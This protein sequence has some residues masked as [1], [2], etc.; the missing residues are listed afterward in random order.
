M[1]TL[2]QQLFNHR[3]FLDLYNRYENELGRRFPFFRLNTAAVAGPGIDFLTTAS[4]IAASQV[5]EPTQEQVD[6]VVSELYYRALYDNQF[7]IPIKS[8]PSHHTS[9]FVLGGIWG[10]EA[11]GPVPTPVMV[12]GK[13]PGAEATTRRINFVEPSGEE[14]RKQVELAGGDWSHWYVTNIVRHRQLSTSSNNL[15]KDWIKNCLPL[16]QMELQIVRPTHILL[17]GTEAVK[18]LY[19]AYPQRDELGKKKSP[20]LKSA[21]AAVDTF[22][23]PLLD[24]TTHEAKVFACWHP[25]YILSEPKR[26]S[27]LANSV[28]K[29]VK[30]VR[31]HDVE[32][33]ENP[34]FHLAVRTT[35]Q[36]TALVDSL[37][38]MKCN[39]FAVD[40]EW[41][42][43][44][45]TEPNSYVRTV[46]FAWAGNA[47]A[48]VVLHAAGGEAAFEGGIIECAI[49]QLRRLLKGT[50]ERPVRIIGHYLNADMPWLISLGL[51]LRAEF[52]AP[53]EITGWK[54]RGEMA[55]WD[56]TKYLGGFDT[57]LAGHAVEETAELK[58][59][60][61]LNQRKGLPRYDLVLQKW[62]KQYCSEHGLKDAE[63][64]GYGHCLHSLS[65][66]QLEDG[67]WDQIGKLV[68]RKYAGKVKGLVAGRV[69]DVAVTNWH[70]N[71][72]ERQPWYKLKTV[73]SAVDKR[74]WI[75]GPRLTPDHR[76]VT[77]RGKV[78]VE[79]LIVGVDQIATD[80]WE[81]TKDQLSVL[82]GSGLGD[83]GFRVKTEKGVA[84]GFGQRPEKAAYADWKAEVFSEFKPS[85][86]KFKDHRRY[87]LP[88]SRQLYA[89]LLRFPRQPKEQHPKRKLTISKDLLD[90]LGMLGLAVW[91]QDDGSLIRCGSSGRDYFGSRIYCARLTKLE[92]QIALS[93][94]HD[95][96]GASVTYSE[97]GGF[98]YFAKESFQRLH[99]AISPY[100]HPVMAYKC[101]MLSGK[102]VLPPRI[103][104]SST[105]FY[106]TVTDVVLSPL[107]TARLY[108]NVRYC[109][110]TESGNFL[111]Q[112]GFVSNCPDEVLVGIPHG[113]VTPFGQPVR[114][115]YGANDAS[116]TFMLFELFNGVDGQPGLLDRDR[117]GNSSRKAFWTSMRAAPAFGEM[118]MTGICVD[119]SEAD[120][121]SQHYKLAR[122]RILDRLRQDINWQGNDEIAAFNPNSI[123]HVN[124]FLFGEQFGKKNK[125]TN[126]PV[127]VR[128]EGALSLGL[129][130]YKTT[131]KRPKLWDQVVAKGEQDKY[132]PSADK[133]ALAI[134]ADRHPAVAL[135][136]DYRKIAQ[137]TKTVLRPSLEEDDDAHVM[138]ALMV[139]D[140]EKEYDGG[141]F[142]YI[143]ADGRVRSQFF[144]TKETGRASSARPALQNW[145]FDPETEYLTDRGW[146]PVAEL[147]HNDQIAQF[148]PND[149]SITFV[150]PTDTF[151]S[152]YS[153]DMVRL[154]NPKHFDLLVTPEHRCLLR[155]RKTTRA[156]HYHE[157]SAADYGGDYV[158]IHAGIYSAGTKSLSWAEAAWLVAVQADGHYVPSGGIRF[159]FTLERKI[160]RFHRICND[161]GLSYTRNG[162]VFY[163]G[164][165]NNRKWVDFAKSYLTSDK[166]LG[167]WLLQFDRQTLDF[168]A[169]EFRYW[170]GN[171]RRGECAF[172]TQK[173]SA[174]WYQIVWT[175]S[176]IRT[177]MRIYHNG[178][179]NAKN[180]FVVDRRVRGQLN[181]TT[182]G[183]VEKEL[184]PYSGKI[185]CV[186][187]PTGWVVVRRGGCV[188]VSGNSKTLEKDYRAIFERYRPWMG[189]DYTRP[190]RSI[191]VASPGCVLVDADWTGAELAIAAW[192][193]G[194]ANMIEHVR[195]NN[196]DESDPDYYDI[197]SSIAVQA[198][199][200]TV[201]AGNITNEAL[202]RKLRLAV[203]ISYA[204]AIGVEVGFPLPFTKRALEIV[205]KVNLRHAAKTVMF[206]RLYGQQ[207]EAAARTIR[208]QGI[209]C[210]VDE[211]EVLSMT[212]S[213]TYPDLDSFFAEAAGRP[214]NP[215]YMCTAMGRY[216][217]FFETRERS[218]EGGQ[219][220]EAMNFEMQSNVADGMQ[221]A[222]DHLYWFRYENYS[223]ERMYRIILQV[224]DAV[225]LE[226]PIKSLDWVVNT[227]IPTCMSERVVFYSSDFDGRPKSNVQYRLKAPPPDI[228]E[229]WSV[230]LTKA[231]CER[232]GINPKY[233][234]A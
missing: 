36:L 205:E 190:L 21:M 116:G 98:F 63:L 174:D 134:L 221:R 175:I 136:R 128:P 165:N 96:F 111:T 201:P 37:L 129:T 10:R 20:A 208:Q 217:R 227:V 48:S 46:Q 135:L 130:P 147:Q 133:E 160:D 35:E 39:T 73:S 197:H 198:F 143:L 72:V 191:L 182:S 223:P 211:A 1:P 32:R 86:R 99:A 43:A 24:G 209:D 60:A 212:I 2:F 30:L 148:D 167:P 121:M 92:S 222:L 138:A 55:P 34:P 181:T 187:V 149:E 14:L 25:S 57:I 3:S 11:T 78:A 28:S 168:F 166:V 132:N 204:E 5:V 158:N 232:L 157:V 216:R 140:E 76:V 16:L 51:D 194:D 26:T 53:P 154:S 108:D 137:M 112:I 95:K 170:D 38:A 162:R 183:C 89:I 29:F 23:I 75:I 19:S 220:R 125:S 172:S 146:V 66:V 229:R 103:E 218:V 185:Y 22:S 107:P 120:R 159:T 69:A 171:H 81:F 83:G 215:G 101:P 122:D 109:L 189:L 155:T 13:I 97:N 47:A 153:G 77:H 106:E 196:L 64:E 15:N 207:A 177:R 94:F 123:Y 40:A 195:R 127:R 151:S 18:G 225:V 93:W 192:M 206:G 4:G 152:D 17:L 117:F 105:V 104:K 179:P 124:E 231:D 113:D 44:Y 90:S 58:L 84:F 45:P 71:T 193:S 139:D 214:R 62:K 12:I 178:N 224:H 188:V 131:G 114:D 9:Q 27:E 61:I 145:C 7:G 118:H 228:Y 150:K 141:I 8:G 6:I 169:E 102:I 200:L 173:A 156:K 52:D 74:G 33:V 163:L 161:L 56:S 202:C 31:G 176:G 59:E 203:G 54:D 144:Q 126:V 230:D 213:H 210:S 142:R 234:K 91:Y 65:L 67:S 82:L 199:R 110:T 88:T 85:L 100:I 180:C 186:T 50:A 68:R 41:H 70:E 226:V 219:S 233:A 87:E 184:V 115:S 79:S 164:L 119:V 49:P 42:G 80:E